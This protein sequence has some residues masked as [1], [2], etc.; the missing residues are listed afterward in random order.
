MERAG[1]TVGAAKEYEKA[2]R[3]APLNAAVHNEAAVAQYR[4]GRL[5]DAIA[6]LKRAHNLNPQDVGILTNLG[7]CLYESRDF[8]GAINSFEDAL[9][10]NKTEYTARFNLANTFS[11]VLMYDRANREFSRVLEVK[12]DYLPASINLLRNKETVCDWQGRDERMQNLEEELR[13]VFAKGQVS[14]VRPWHA[15]SYPL[16]LD[17]LRSIAVSFAY[18]TEKEVLRQ[19]LVPFKHH[20]GAQFSFS[21]ARRLRIA[22]V[23]YCISS[24]PTTQ[25]IKGLFRHHS[26]QMIHASCYALNM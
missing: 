18:Q 7:A 24:H 17:M 8:Q 6:N 10:L 13:S 1:D 21:P 14:P 16:P 11:E 9:S 25:L 23:S 22:Y 19:G 26:R 5:G 3:L 4:L 2:M 20:F 15:L 12:P